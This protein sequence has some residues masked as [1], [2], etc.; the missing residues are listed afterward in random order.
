ME[1]MQVQQMLEL[2]MPTAGVSDV[3]MTRVGITVV[4][5]L[6]DGWPDQSS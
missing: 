6:I 1:S 4:L 3:M 2:Q 5:N